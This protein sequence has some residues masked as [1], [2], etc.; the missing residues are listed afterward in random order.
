MQSHE[1]SVKIC[2]SCG[3]PMQKRSDFGSD[4]LGAAHLSYCHHCMKDG[5][6]HDE[7]TTLHEKIAKSVEMAVKMG[8]DRNDAIEMATRVLPKL[9]RWCDL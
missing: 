2:Q 8:M 1:R 4:R 7:G 9:K 3:M 6:F 5:K